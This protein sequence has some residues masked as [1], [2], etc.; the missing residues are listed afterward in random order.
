MFQF[1]GEGERHL[2]VKPVNS[3][4]H[5]QLVHRMAPSYRDL[6][7]GRGSMRNPGGCAWLRRLWP[8]T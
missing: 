6:P 5:I 8:S 2:A 1:A 3:P 7:R 4:G